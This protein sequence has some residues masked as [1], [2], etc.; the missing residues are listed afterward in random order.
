VGSGA[1]MSVGAGSTVASV[2]LDGGTLGG[3]N[4][5][6]S[7][8][9]ITSSGSSTILPGTSTAPG[10]LDVSSLE[11]TS[12]DTMTFQLG[13]QPTAGQ[14]PVP[15]VDYDQVRV[16]PPTPQ[17]TIVPF[18]L[19]PAIDLAGVALDTEALGAVAAEPGTVYTLISNPTGLPIQ[20]TFTG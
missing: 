5:Q 17:L 7:A 9:N 1:T 16:V 10:L 3:S 2:D 4:P 18:D 19:P 8:G 13:P 15:G 20:G 14:Q 12:G 11:L 6:G